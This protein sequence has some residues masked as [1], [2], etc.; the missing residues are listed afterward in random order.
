MTCDATT[1]HN[2][3]VHGRRTDPDKLRDLIATR[4]GTV[5]AFRVAARAHLPAGVRRG[6]GRSHVTQVL[7]GKGDFSLAAAHAAAKALECTI[8]DFTEPDQHPHGKTA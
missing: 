6:L 2:R 1:G 8:E 3:A 5:T 4:Y 7:A